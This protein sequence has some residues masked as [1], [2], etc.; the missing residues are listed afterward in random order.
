MKKITYLLTL[1]TIIS[2]CAICQDNND[3]EIQ[4]VYKHYVGV[5]VGATTGIGLAYKYHPRKFG[6]QIT[7]LPLLVDDVFHASVAYTTFF[8]LKKKTETELVLFAA[9]HVTDFYTGNY[10]YNFGIGP[11]FELHVDEIS[12]HILLGYGIYNVPDNITALPTL[13]L[14]LFYRF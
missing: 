1:L 8:S 2:Y 3:A 10:T 7:C 12:G 14:A 11:G 5:N 13:D 6:H 4:E 9:H